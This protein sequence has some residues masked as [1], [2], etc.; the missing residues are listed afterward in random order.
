MVQGPIRVFPL[1][2]ASQRYIL[3]NLPFTKATQLTEFDFNVRPSLA[4]LSYEQS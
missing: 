1:F 2:L 3:C 4:A